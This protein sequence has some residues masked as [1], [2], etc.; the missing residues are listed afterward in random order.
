MP[1]SEN[2]EIYY[3]AIHCYRSVSQDHLWLIKAIYVQQRH[4]TFMRS[5]PNFPNVFYNDTKP[6]IPGYLAMWV[7]VHSRPGADLFNVGL[8]HV[9]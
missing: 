1:P 2:H 8:V 7:Q 3:S 9:Q 4:R 5:G 6:R